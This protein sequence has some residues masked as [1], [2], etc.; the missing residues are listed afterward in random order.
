RTNCELFAE[1]LGSVSRTAQRDRSVLH[2]DCRHGVRRYP[3]H[4]GIC[5]PMRATGQKEKAQVQGGD[6]RNADPVHPRPHRAGLLHREC[7]PHRQQ[8]R[9]PAISQVTPDVTDNCQSNP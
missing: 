4:H 8:Q 6:E 3:I 9:Q 2:P 5:L 1:K 7:R